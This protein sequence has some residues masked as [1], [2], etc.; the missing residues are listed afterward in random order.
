MAALPVPVQISRDG[1]QVAFHRWLTDSCA[2]LPRGHKDVR[3]D[4]IRH[5]PD[6]RTK[7]V[8]IGERRAYTVDRGSRC[9]SFSIAIQ[10]TREHSKSY[11]G[12][13]RAQTTD[14]LVAL[15]KQFPDIIEPSQAGY[16]HHFPSAFHPFCA[17]ERIR[18]GRQLV[19]RWVRREPIG[20]GFRSQLPDFQRPGAIGRRCVAREDLSQELDFR[21]L[22][23][24][25]F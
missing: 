2:G 22:I 1:E 8:Q 9:P 23:N 12:I 20:C 21:S 15:S 11:K 3:S 6:H 25:T 24:C 4:F 5:P 16:S 13:P 7:T 19:A 18:P 17:R 14:T 10:V